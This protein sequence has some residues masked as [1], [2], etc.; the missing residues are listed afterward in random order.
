MNIIQISHFK[1]KNQNYEPSIKL[2]IFFINLVIFGVV[3][4]PEHVTFKC[5]FNFVF[6]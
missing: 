3:E 4:S 6:S 1:K 2:Y 5:A